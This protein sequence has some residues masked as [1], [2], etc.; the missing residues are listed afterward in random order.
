MI[1]INFLLLSIIAVFSSCGQNKTEEVII[2]QDGK[3]INQTENNGEND[4]DKNVS[5]D[6]IINKFY[7][8]Q[9]D[10]KELDKLMSF[11]FYQKTPYSKFKESMIQKNIEFGKLI[12]KK[13][14]KTEF[15]ED[16]NAISVKLNVTYE[17]ETTIEKIV[18]IRETEKSIY[19]IFEYDL[20][21]I[22]E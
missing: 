3:I 19:K 2:N 7:E 13:I 9:T 14:T 1:R 8:N 17:N 22:S 21:I 4:N 16:N 15:S 6:R 12:E 5:S 20:E 18:L 11:R 10:I